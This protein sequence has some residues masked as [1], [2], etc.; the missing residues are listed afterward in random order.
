MERKTAKRASESS[1]VEYV[2][3]DLMDGWMEEGGRRGW[4][5][6]TNKPEFFL[7]LLQRA[8]CVGFT[9]ILFSFGGVGGLFELS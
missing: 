1:R 6:G 2:Q 3:D 9:R 5:A 8:F 4:G 7:M